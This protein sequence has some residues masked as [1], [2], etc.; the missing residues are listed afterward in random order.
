M[1]V[2]TWRSHRKA[3]EPY[4]Y[5]YVHQKLTRSRTASSRPV[6]VWLTFLS[7]P[8]RNACPSINNKTEQGA[9][10]HPTHG[11]QWSHRHRDNCF[12]ANARMYTAQTSQSDPQSLI[13]LECH[14]YSRNYCHCCFC[15][16]TSGPVRKSVVLRGVIAGRTLRTCQVSIS[17]WCYYIYNNG[18][19]Q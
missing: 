3:R 16:N 12:V 17:I 10:T 14:Y 9:L 2:S 5:R 7:L 18:T 13:R 15:T 19:V 1:H 11:S 6:I 8:P 4:N